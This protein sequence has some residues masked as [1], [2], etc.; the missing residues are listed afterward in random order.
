MEECEL[1]GRQT[2]DIYVVNV[3][4]VELRACASCAK[5]KKVIKTELERQVKAKAT[6]ARPKRVTDEDMVLID[7]YASAIR[8]A[9]EQMKLPIKVLAEM[10]NEKE[11]LLLRVEEERTRPSIALTKKL[12]KILKIK[13]TEE[14]KEDNTK[15]SAK[16]VQDP[17]IGD[18][19][20]N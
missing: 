11:H 1:C 8:R 16:R 9:R 4:N 17:T 2:K 7:N 19:M 13:L 20:E 18:F 14:V 6:S 15:Y 10:I 12:E 3:E 5:G